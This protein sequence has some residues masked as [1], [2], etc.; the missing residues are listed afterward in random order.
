MEKTK[1]APNGSG[2]SGN[3]RRVPSS[4]K[5]CFTWNNYDSGS[6]GSD[7]SI[8]LILKNL[9]P[10]DKYV[11]GEEIGENGTPHLQG[12]IKFAKKCRPLEMGIFSKAIHWEKARGSEED[13]WIYCTKDGKYVQ[14]IKRIPKDPLRGKEFRPWQSNIMEK[15]KMEPDDRKIIW[16]YDEGNSGKTTLCKHI[17]LTMDAIVLSGK[18]NDIRCGVAKWFENKTN[19]DVAI[20]SF[21]RTVEDYISYESIEQVKDGMFFNGKYES[22]MCI[23]DSPH[24]ICFAN[25]RPEKCKMTQDRWEIYEISNGELVDVTDKEDKESLIEIDTD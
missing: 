20:F 21:V 15:I 23:F 17:A 5:W 12:F 9:D 14:N 22:G 6:D 18:G 24:V 7:G 13:N 25:F 8:S 16:I 4:K 2:D 3:T 10:N 19:L 11:I 1:M